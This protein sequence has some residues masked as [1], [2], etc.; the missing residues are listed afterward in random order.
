MTATLKILRDEH[1]A[2]TSVLRTLLLLLA[3]SRSCA[4]PPDFALLRAMLFYVAEFPEKRHHRKESDLLFPKLRARSPL[5]RPLLDRLD[6]DHLRGESKIREL[7]HALTAYEIL[8][9][10]RREQFE[11]AAKRYVDFYMH[12]MALEEREILPLALQVLSP[13]D[14]EE[15]DA[16]MAMD[17]DPL[18][19]HA[20]EAVY[21]T[22]FDRIVFGTP[23]PFGLGLPQSPMPAPRASITGS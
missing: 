14:W 15:L 20:V 21:R 18:A 2:L 10:A 3:D 17:P 8:G 9:E 22:L 7:E 16:G 1:L 4:R 23:A 11:E 19:G 12:H 6:E 5:S 13:E